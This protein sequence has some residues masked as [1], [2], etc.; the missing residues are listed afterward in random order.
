MI[1]ILMLGYAFVA[2]ESFFLS[3]L[4][5]AWLIPAFYAVSRASAFIHKMIRKASNYVEMI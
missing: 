4:I 2:L 3:R 1:F 5:R